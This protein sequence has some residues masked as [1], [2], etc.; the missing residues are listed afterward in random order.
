MGVF[1]SLAGVGRCWLGLGGIAAGGFAETFVSACRR[2][3]HQISCNQPGYIA[4]PP[5]LP[6]IMSLKQYTRDTPRDDP[7]V[8][9]LFETA[10]E[11][12][13]GWREAFESKDVERCLDL[14]APD[15]ILYPG[16]PASGQTFSGREQ[17]RALIDGSVKF[18]FSPMHESTLV[19]VMNETTLHVDFIWWAKGDPEMKKGVA[20]A[21]FVKNEAGKWLIWRN[22][23]N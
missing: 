20:T 3:L 11:V 6:F 17:L 7:N 8:P 14:Y 10:E 12:L 19:T 5:N 23:W 22:I 16:P 13:A 4:S 9:T 21:I 15:C 18:G 2:S 1:S